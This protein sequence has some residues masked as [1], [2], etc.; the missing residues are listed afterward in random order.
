[1]DRP[2]KENDA[3]VSEK[4][5][6]VP[7]LTHFT[8]QVASLKD[9]TAAAQLITKLRGGWLSSAALTLHSLV[10]CYEAGG[11]AAQVMEFIKGKSTIH[12]AAGYFEWRFILTFLLD[13]L[14]V[15]QPIADFL[16][17]NSIYIQKS[18]VN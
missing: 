2:G 3:R 8:I 17:C 5:N 13:R 14:S 9:E 18:P 6:A 12:I 1:M 7:A 4:E 15:S 16:S 10:N 11:G